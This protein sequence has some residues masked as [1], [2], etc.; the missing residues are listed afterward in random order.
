LDEK[1]ENMEP[2]NTI[3]EATQCIESFEGLPKDFKLPI[4]DQLQ[5]P[6]GINMAIITDSILKRG[7]MPDGFQQKEGYRIYQYKDGE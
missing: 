3:E 2:I 4:S 7:W 5:D 6:I 1:I